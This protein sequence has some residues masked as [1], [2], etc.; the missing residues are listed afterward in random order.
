MRPTSGEPSMRG[1]R[2]CP[3]S[4]KAPSANPASFARTA[5]RS[6]QRRS[7]RLPAHDGGTPAPLDK[8]V[9][10]LPAARRRDAGPAGLQPQQ[11]S[12]AYPFSLEH[13]LLR[14]IDLAS[15]FL[16][17]RRSASPADFSLSAHYSAFSDAIGRSRTSPNH[18]HSIVL[19]HGNALNFQS[20]F[21][22]C[23]MKNRLPDPSEICALD[24][25]HEFGRSAVCLV[26]AT[27]DND[28]SIFSNL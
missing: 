23:E 10:G 18:S 11:L 9:P 7:R 20:K 21:F 6:Q 24:F 5:E 15:G 4:A 12:A 17:R 27:I 13:S 26:S 8:P 28:W 14:H 22:L 25:K 19:S 16:S 2:R 3:T 1:A